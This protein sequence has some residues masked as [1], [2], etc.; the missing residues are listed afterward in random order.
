[1]N[2]P[3][4]PKT[5]SPLSFI[6]REGF[7][8]SSK[9]FFEPFFLLI[10]FIHMKICKKCN[11]EMKYYKPQDGPYYVCVKCGDVQFPLD[12]EKSKKNSN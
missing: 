11:I 2:S 8:E 10:V 9:K 5:I 7:D 6:C 3:Y 1:M 4:S 12:Y